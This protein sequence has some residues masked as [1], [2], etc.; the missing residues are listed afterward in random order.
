MKT[1]KIY[2]KQAFNIL[3]KGRNEMNADIWK[4]YFDLYYFQIICDHENKKQQE[5]NEYYNKY[6][7]EYTSDIKE[8]IRKDYYL[9][10]IISMPDDVC[11]YRFFKKMLI[12]YTGSTYYEELKELFKEE[13]DENNIKYRIS[14]VKEILN[15]DYV[16]SK[17]N[18]LMKSLEDGDTESAIGKAKELVETVCKHI[19]EQERIEIRK[20]WS[21]TELFNKTKEKL[22]FLPEHVIDEGKTKKSL[23]NMLQ[24]LSS[25]DSSIAVIRNTYGAGHGKSPEFLKLDKRYAQLMVGAASDIALFLLSTY[26]DKKAQK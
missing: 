17:A 1:N 5:E 24:G 8:D 13:P 3:W 18:E 26:E 25:I 11:R 12:C 10:L 9:D 14:Q 7:S 23:E 20:G 4:Q 15:R 19:L 2:W 6:Q 16:N 21:F 22:D